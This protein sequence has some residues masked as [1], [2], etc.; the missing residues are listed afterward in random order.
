MTEFNEKE[1]R[2]SANNWFDAKDAL[3]E[4]D[5]LKW[6]VAALA[7]SVSDRGSAK[8]EMAMNAKQGIRARIDYLH[9]SLRRL[10]KHNAK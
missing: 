6:A 7:E 4:L 2:V 1:D 10:L 9:D 5:N 3:A 8:Y